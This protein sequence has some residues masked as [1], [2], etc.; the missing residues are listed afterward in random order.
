[1]RPFSI[2]FNDCSALAT[3]P[4]GPELAGGALAHTR[5]FRYIKSLA[6]T[7]RHAVRFPDGYP[8]MSRRAGNIKLTMN[9]RF[10]LD[11]SRSRFP[12]IGSGGANDDQIQV[13]TGDFILK[14]KYIG[15]VSSSVLLQSIVTLQYEPTPNAI[16]WGSILAYQSAPLLPGVAPQLQGSF[17]SL[18][19]AQPNELQHTFPVDRLVLSGF[20]M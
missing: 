18:A 1:M 7:A 14:I 11:E 13:Y 3:T 4:D 15:G 6:T 9:R 12:P 10:E 2:F 17:Q 16:I 20:W 19:P 5:A 8:L